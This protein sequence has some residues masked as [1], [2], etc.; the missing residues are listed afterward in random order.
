[1]S[2]I[3]PSC[4]RH[5]CAPAQCVLCCQIFVLTILPECRTI[6]ANPDNTVSGSTKERQATATRIETEYNYAEIEK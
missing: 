2:A 3:T 5:E 6:D 4:G 1:M